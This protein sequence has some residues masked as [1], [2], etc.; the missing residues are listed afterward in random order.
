MSKQNNR[1]IF[2]FSKRIKAVKMVDQNYLNN[3]GHD[4]FLVVKIDGYKKAPSKYCVIEHDIYGKAKSTI[5]SE[6]ELI[7]EFGVDVFERHFK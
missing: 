3:G 2:A 4:E 1:K 5:L 7:S 6:S